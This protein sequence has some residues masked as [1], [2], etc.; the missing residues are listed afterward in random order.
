[1]YQFWCQKDLNARPPTATYSYQ[2]NTPVILMPQSSHHYT[3][4]EVLAFL[5]TGWG[6]GNISDLQLSFL[7]GPED[8]Q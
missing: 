1:M 6:I 8:D 7:Y 2:K 3:E 5:E 4:A